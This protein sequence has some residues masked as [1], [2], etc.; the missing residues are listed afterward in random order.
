MEDKL[1]AQPGLAGELKAL[2]RWS[3]CCTYM[4]RQSPSRLAMSQMAFFAA[5]ALCDLA[6]KPQTMTELLE[7]V[8][9]VS[10]GSLKETYA[11]FLPPSAKRPGG[12]GWL[13]R[14]SC[15]FDGRRK[16]LCLSYRGRQ[17]IEGV[18]KFL[19]AI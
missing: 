4:A 12:L 15:P 18:P 13:V 14:R 1:G 2:G 7:M 10:G 11:V 3:L 17:V 9:D 6:K 19:K 5:A 16:L 8:G